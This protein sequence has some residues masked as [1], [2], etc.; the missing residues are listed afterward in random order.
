M[1]VRSPVRVPGSRSPVWIGASVLASICFGVLFFLPPLLT[2]LDANAVFGWRVVITLPVMTV[3]ILTAGGG[4][5]IS[6]TVRR[7]IH[8]PAMALALIVDAALIGLQ[9][10]LFSWAPGS[11]HGLDVAL[12]YLL[13]PLMMVVVGAVVFHER[14][15]AARRVAVAF[16]AVGTAVAVISAGQV[17]WPTFAVAL[18]YPIY[19]GLRRA[20]A[21]DAAGALWCE[22]LLLAPVAV[23]CV[24]GGTA[25]RTFGAHV[26]LWGPLLLFGLLSAVALASYLAASAKLSFG[27]FGILSYLEPILLIVVSVL[28]LGEQLSLLDV[29]TYLPLAMALGILAAD[30]LRGRGPGR[31]TGAA[32]RL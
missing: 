26:E 24:L 27:V 3:L 9:V 18:G 30:G 28:V 25:R 12:G 11:G 23:V 15:T 19:F 32:G 31:E 29:V 10:W 2:P 4:R 7:S 5:R 8:R 22:L 14:L 13:L 16:A 6:R 21:F 17:A 20:F 1:A